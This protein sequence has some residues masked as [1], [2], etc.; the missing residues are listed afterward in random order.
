MKPLINEIKANFRNIY[1]EIEKSFINYIEKYTK[2]DKIKALIENISK[3]EKYTKICYE[4]IENFISNKSKDDKIVDHLNIVIVGRAGIGKTTLLNAVLNYDQEECLKTDFGKNCTLGEPEYHESKKM[5]LL[6]I[7]DSRGIDIKDYNIK[8]MSKSINKFIQNNLKSGDPDK[9]VHCIWYCINGTRFEDIE[10]ETLKE[11]SKIYQANSIPIIIVYTQ[12]IINEHVENME[13]II[14]A[15]KLYDFIPVLAKKT[16]VFRT[17]I[18]P[19]GIKELKEISFKRAREAVKYS[20]YENYILQLQIDK[21]IKN[22]L[23][24][25]NKKLDELITNKIKIKLDKMS[26]RKSDE[27]IC[28]Y[29]NNLLFDLISNSIYNET[30]TYV[31]INSEKLIAEFSKEVIDKPL[32]DSFETKFNDYIKNKSED[33]CKEILD[34]ERSQINNFGISQEEIKTKIDDLINENKSLY[35]KA[36]ITFIKKYFEDLFQSYAKNF[37]E[38]SQKIYKEI[39]KKNN[40]QN[41]I[42]KLVK[43]RFDEIE[44]KLK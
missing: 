8:Q 26:E 16:K 42:Q 6:R 11:L 27:E 41:C 32:K 23:E 21:K 36:W 22:Q 10:E 33:I 25:M 28:D 1:S 40:F 19:F 18:E 17:L 9:F 34:K 31:S 13:K 29:L 4:K 38:E 30:K 35:Q 14:N 37:K 7:A 5:P 20:N 24:D 15:K 43:E 39:L 3:E 12:A 44:A 2:E